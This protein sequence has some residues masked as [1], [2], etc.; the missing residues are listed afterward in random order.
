M[1]CRNCDEIKS[2]VP[3][4]NAF[5]QVALDELDAV[6][7]AAD[8]AASLA[9]PNA[10]SE[11]STATTVQPRSREPYRI[12]AFSAAQIE[13][14]TRRQIAHYVGELDVDPSAPDALAFAV[15][16]FPVLFGLMR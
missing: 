15:V 3:S 10:V 12:G 8:A 2:N 9:R 4:G 7:D 5:G 16:L 6:G 1:E 14:P 13:C 11:M